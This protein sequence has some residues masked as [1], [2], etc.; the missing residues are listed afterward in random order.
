MP[1]FVGGQQS[2][3]STSSQINTH[4]V[5]SVRELVT[6]LGEIGNWEILCTNLGVRQ[7][8]MS[9]LTNSPL[10]VSIK[11]KRCLESYFNSGRAH[12]EEVIATV[13]GPG[14]FNE[15]VAKKIADKYLL[16]WEDFADKHS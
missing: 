12:W 13:A 11:K 9:E 6:T 2:A 15:R 7:A 10:H 8:V 14:I 5:G 1:I 4:S 3:G 16:D